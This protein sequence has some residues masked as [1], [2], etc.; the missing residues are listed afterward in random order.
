[1]YPKVAAINPRSKILTIVNDANF[2]KALELLQ[3]GYESFK[4]F[5]NT[6]MHC[7]QISNESDLLKVTLATFNP[8]ADNFTIFYENFD[9]NN[10][11][12]TM[13]NFK[14]KIAERLRNLNKYPLKVRA[15]DHP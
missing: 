13:K 6:I 3:F 12:I 10:L 15:N 8:F 7:R 9:E 11:E 2:E 1:M 5:D 14:S 4:L